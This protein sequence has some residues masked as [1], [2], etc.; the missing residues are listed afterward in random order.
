MPQLKDGQGMNRQL[1]K[2]QRACKD[3]QTAHKENAN[4]GNNLSP[5]PLKFTDEKI[6]KKQSGL[7]REKR[8]ASTPL[9]AA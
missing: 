1:T 4:Q 5:L 3:V 8:A 7:D 6:L 2:E 9:M